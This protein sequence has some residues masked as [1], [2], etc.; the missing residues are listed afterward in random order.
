MQERAEEFKEAQNLPD[1]A[2]RKESQSLARLTAQWAPKRRKVG[3]AGTY[4]PDGCEV[5]DAAASSKLLCDH[6]AGVFAGGP[7][8]VQK[9]S[10]FLERYANPF[11]QVQWRLGKE[12]FDVVIDCT[13][14]SAC[15]PD[16]IPYSAWGEVPAPCRAALHKAY[17]PWLDEG[18][19]PEGFNDAYLWLLPKGSS[20]R[21]S[22]CSVLR[23][24]SDTRPLSGS[25]TDSKLLAS[26]FKHAANDAVGDWA[27]RAQRRFICGRS[28]LE[29]AVEVEPHA[30]RGIFQSEK[31]C[32]IGAVRMA[33]L[34]PS[35]PWLGPTC[36]WLSP[37]RDSPP[38]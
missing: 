32:C 1:Y 6:W 8:D 23:E 34:Q 19:V 14:G 13:R 22:A 37:T 3:L 2:V 31:S 15:G 16:G 4:M 9:A 20:D 33:L 18:R 24:P 10:E 36:G 30:M 25:N 38:M 11:P 7:I 26:A 5:H 27:V 28:V 29:N 35:P 21:D 12:Q 17:L